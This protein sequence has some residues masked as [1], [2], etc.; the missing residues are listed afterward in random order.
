[1]K[2]SDI[3]LLKHFEDLE[4]PRIE[5]TK[6]HRLIDIICLSVCAVIGGADGWEEIE[7]F[8]KDKLDW[9]KTFLHLPN[10]IPSHDTIARVFRRLKPGAFQERFLQWTSALCE[11]LGLKHVAI[12]GKTLRRSHD[13]NSAKKALHS[14][15]AWS[16]ENHL[17]LGQETVDEKSNEIT[18]IPELLKILELQGAIVTI[19]AMGCQKEIAKQIRD[20]GGDYVLAVKGNQPLLFE[21]IKEHFQ[22][23]HATDFAESHARRTTT[24]G[25]GHGREEERYYCVTKA[26]A[27]LPVLED[28]WRDLKTIGQVVTMTKRDGRETS[29]VRY[30][31]SSRPPR[32]KAFAEVVRGH[33]A[34]ENSLH[35]VLDVTFDEDRSRI[36][37][38]HGPENFA[39][40][41]RIATSM[42]KRDT[43][44]K[45][46]IKRRRKRAGWNNQH[47]LDLLI[48][49][50]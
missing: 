50:N 48:N 34:I 14:V 3:E 12:D 26:P 30:F 25:R 6:R 41:R 21:A 47:L 32:V 11:K 39:L 28:E 1:M 37:K 23:L 16:V 46:S 24:R 40:L 2:V 10:G 20:A 38:D 44:S 35:W 13:R 45:Q 17:S 9:L 33:W 7:D 43:S 4:D 49:E 19:D 8:G 29:E 5:R 36:R 31:I 22:H 18:A 42:I 27:S 15:S